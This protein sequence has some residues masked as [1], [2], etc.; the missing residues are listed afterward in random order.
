[1]KIVSLFLCISLAIGANA[2]VKVDES[3]RYMDKLLQ[4]TFPQRGGVLGWTRLNGFW[5][6]VGKKSKVK[7]GNTSFGKRDTL[8]LDQLRGTSA[9]S[10]STSSGHL[11]HGDHLTKRSI[12]IRKEKEVEVNMGD[13]TVSGLHGLRRLGDCSPPMWQLGTVVLSCY[14]SLNGVT[15][16]YRGKIARQKS[17]GIFTT[18]SHQDEITADAVMTN[19]K[20][21]IE[22]S[23]TP[24]GQPTLSSWS[25]MP[26]DL[27][28]G[29]SRSLNDVDSDLRSSLRKQL[30]KHIKEKLDSFLYGQLKSG[31][32]TA[33]KVD[34]LPM[35]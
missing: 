1:M 21:F 20:A 14:V 30:K 31:L 25:V 6:K 9:K 22:V 15:A 32:E 33:V 12:K 27:H 7:I 11:P 10:T 19:A 8:A 18:G 29:Y 23:G 3:N 34:P 35:P 26:Y 5:I 2:D 28:M 4:Q 13:G 24:G 16:N 17:T